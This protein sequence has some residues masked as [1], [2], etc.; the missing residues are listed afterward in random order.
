MEH[1]ELTAALTNITDKAPPFV[2]GQPLTTDTATYDI[3]GRSYYA[4][5]KA[6]F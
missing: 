1:L 2:S 6:K 3:I 4:G 5:F